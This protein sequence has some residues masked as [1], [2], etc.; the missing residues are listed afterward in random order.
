MP[1]PPIPLEHLSDCRY[2]SKP[3]GVF[4]F[5]QLPHRPNATL[6]ANSGSQ[7]L[8]FGVRSAEPG[9]PVALAGFRHV[10]RHYFGSFHNTSTPRKRRPDSDVA[11]RSK[12]FEQTWSQQGCCVDHRVCL[13]AD[14]PHCYPEWHLADLLAH[15]ALSPNYSRPRDTRKPSIR[16]STRK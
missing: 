3:A 11:R 4:F 8:N 2:R 9:T 16:R 14:I 12:S 10:F 6:L 5:S 1:T 13:L 15:Q 7:A